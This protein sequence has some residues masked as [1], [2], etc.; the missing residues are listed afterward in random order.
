MFDEYGPVPSGP[1]SCNEDGGLKTVAPR[2]RLTIGGR[3][4]EP[5]GC[6]SDRS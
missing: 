5:G 1:Y 4:G 6:T 3:S 2:A